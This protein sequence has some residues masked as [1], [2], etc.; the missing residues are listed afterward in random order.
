M[1]VETRRFIE[2]RLLTTHEVA[3][4]LQV[5]VVTVHQWM[6]RGKLDYVV[7]GNSSLFD[8]NDVKDFERPGTPGK[9]GRKPKSADAPLPESAASLSTQ[10]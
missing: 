3:Q 4:L 5:P 8:R 2:E 10:S 7:K 1:D 9:P 6:S